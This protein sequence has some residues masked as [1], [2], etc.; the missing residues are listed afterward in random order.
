MAE[1]DRQRIQPGVVGD[2]KGL[3]HRHLQH[4]RRQGGLDARDRDLVLGREILERLDIR[5]VRVQPQRR[6]AQRA[7]ADHFRA[8]DAI[9]LRP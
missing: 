5:V 7:Q 2:A 1:T 8:R 9:R 4:H 6:R 3:G